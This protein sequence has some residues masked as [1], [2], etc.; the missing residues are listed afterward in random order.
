MKESALDH[1]CHEEACIRG[2]MLI[3]LRPPPAG[4]CDRLLLMPGGHVIFI[5][6]K[7]LTGRVQPAQRNF[8]AD[9]TRTRVP[10]RVVRSFDEFTDLLAWCEAMHLA[11][12]H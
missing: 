8:M 2:G 3:R 11:A 7:T 6:F 5:E 1:M 10:H 4:I 9:L 12:D